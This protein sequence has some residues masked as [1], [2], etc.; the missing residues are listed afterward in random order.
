MTTYAN[1]FPSSGKNNGPRHIPLL[2]LIAF[3]RENA[4]L[5]FI[6]AIS[7]KKKLTHQIYTQKL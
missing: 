4:L 7:K 6:T 3:L 1:Q 5:F 2:M